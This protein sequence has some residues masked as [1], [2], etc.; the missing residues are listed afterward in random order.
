[1][2]RFELITLILLFTTYFCLRTQ[3]RART[4]K[5][6]ATVKLNFYKVL[7]NRAHLWRLQPNHKGV[8]QAAI[9]GV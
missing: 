7:Q 3:S 4:S 1:M 2:I 6:A 5:T 8:N 9:G